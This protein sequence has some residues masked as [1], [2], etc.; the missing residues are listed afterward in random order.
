MSDESLEQ[1]ISDEKYTVGA[2]YDRT[3]KIYTRSLIPD[4]NGKKALDIGCGTGLNSKYIQQNGFNV[5]GVDISPVA[6]E[7]YIKAGNEGH[8]ADISKSLPYDD[9]TFDLVFA[10]EVIEHLVDTEKFLNEIYRV[11]KTDGNLLLSTP[12]SAFWAY[13]LLTIFGKTPT[14]FQHPGHLR[15][16]TPES[17]ENRVREAGFHHIK[18]SA[19][20]MYFIIGEKYA[21]F[22]SPIL[23]KIPLLKSEVRFK[24]KKRFWHLSKYSRKA[25]KF[26][27]DTIILKVKK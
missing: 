2:E 12:N 22:I 3:S 21:K 11:L 16:F 6:I 27:A 18:V 19:R 13:R 8:V 5:T 25:S 1:R 20:H 7:K 23:T 24:T 26:W 17:L 9:E 14:N 15:F 10:S 4:G